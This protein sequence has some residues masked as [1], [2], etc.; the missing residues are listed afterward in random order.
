MI[1]DSL[2]IM[3]NLHAEYTG[4]GLP[5]NGTPS[6]SAI[7][8]KPWGMRE[9]ALVDPNSNLIRVGHDLDS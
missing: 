9:L 2:D 3:C 5:T 8:D 7:E 4:L 1:T 6:V